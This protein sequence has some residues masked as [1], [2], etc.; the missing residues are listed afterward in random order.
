MFANTH[1]EDDQAASD[2]LHYLCQ[3]KRAAQET[4]RELVNM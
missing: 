4:K 1:K 3:M 2:D